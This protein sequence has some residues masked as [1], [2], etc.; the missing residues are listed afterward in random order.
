VF[1]SG[2]GCNPNGVSLS[3]L[4]NMAYSSLF[5]YFHHLKIGNWNLIL[6]L[7][8][9][10]LTLVDKIRC[11]S[12]ITQLS[13]SAN[14]IKAFFRICTSLNPLPIWWSSGYRSCFAAGHSGVQISALRPIMIE[15]IHGFPHSI[16]T[17]SEA[18]LQ[19]KPTTNLTPFPIHYS[20]I[21]LPFDTISSE[22]LMASWRK[23]TIKFNPI[24]S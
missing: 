10:L 7:L 3:N 5:M 20:L 15:V 19:I 14:W 22:L 24:N 4:R 8:L 21:F 13:P 12:G 18:V 6:L 17:N 16:L 9:L 2:S 1:E 23:S 11:T